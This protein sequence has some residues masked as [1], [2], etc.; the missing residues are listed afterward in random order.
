MGRP[1]KKA[2]PGQKVTLGLRV[3]AE[4][5]ALLLHSAER[6]TR[7]ISQEAELR[8]EQ[9]IRNEDLLD[10]V[11]TLA[12]GQQLAG[13]VRVIAA[14]MF[15]TVDF[16]PGFVAKSSGLFLERDDRLQH[17]YV[18]DQLVKSVQATLEAFRPD[19]NP[20]AS[21]DLGVPAI[22][23]DNLGS[24]MATAVLHVLK[25]GPE[26]GKGYIAELL[27]RSRKEITDDLRQQLRKGTAD[28]NSS[29]A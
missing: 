26:T 13:L 22:N 3:S 2:V 15:V 19:G 7:S 27:F 9:S 25:E 11:L 21:T 8:I 23:P 14:S 28:G 6:H 5:K 10:E 12:Y 17:P 1:T 16:A 24:D 20:S 29:K 4:A 18:F